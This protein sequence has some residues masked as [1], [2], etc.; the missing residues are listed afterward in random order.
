MHRRFYKFTA[1]LVVC[2]MAFQLGLPSRA[3]LQAKE[4]ETVTQEARALE[5]L[6]RG[7]VA[8]KTEEGVFLSWRLMG[9]EVTGANESNSGL[10]GTNFNLYRD[11]KLIETCIADSTNYI[12]KEGTEDSTYYVC[13]LASD[14]TTEID[15]SENVTVWN[16]NYIEI[17]LNK[18]ENRGTQVDKNSGVGTYAANDMSVADLDGDGEYELLVKWYPSNAKD[19]SQGGYTSPTMIDAYKMDGTFLWRVDLGYNFRSGAHYTQFLVYD[20]D[21]DGKAEMCCKTADGTID[22]VGNVIGDP[23]ATIALE[24]GGHTV[25]GNEYLTVFDGV[26]GAAIDTVPYEPARGLI[27]EWGDKNRGERYLAGMAYLG[28]TSTYANEENNPSLIMCR[29]Y[30]GRSGIAAYDFIDDELV[31][32]WKFDTNEENVS[33]DFSGQGA[34]SLSI[35]D[36]D[37]DGYDEI[38]YGS[39]TIDNDGT[40]LY[41]TKQGHGDALY[42]SDLNINHPGLEVFMVHEKYPKENGIAMHDAATGEFLWGYP[43]VNFD[44]GRGSCGDIDPNYSGNEAWCTSEAEDVWRNG[45]TGYVFASDGT[46]LYGTDYNNHVVAKNTPAFNSMI[47]WDGDLGRELLDHGDWNDATS[48]GVGAIYKWDWEAQEQKLILKADGTYTN[49]GTKNNSCL[50]ADILGDWREEVI[51]RTEDSTAIR[52]YTTTNLTNHKL[53]TL[54]HDS[55]YR[56]AV[57]WQNVGYNQPP[58]LSFYLGFDTNW[59]NIPIPNITVKQYVEEYENRLQT[60][61]FDFGSS[62]SYVEPGYIPVNE[63]SIYSQENGFGIVIGDV[64]GQAIAEKGNALFGDW[65]T[66]DSLTF[67]VDGRKGIHTIKLF[68]ENIDNVTI[69]NEE[70]KF[71]QN[72][73]SYTFSNIQVASEGIL[74]ITITGEKVKLYAMEVIRL[75][76]AAV[77]E[78]LIKEA[79]ELLSRLNQDSYLPETVQAVK[80]TIENVKRA[81]NTNLTEKQVGILTKELKDAMDG[82]KEKPDAPT[83]NEYYFDFGTVSSGVED[84]Y[85]GFANNKVYDA[86]TYYG[87]EQGVDARD[88]SSG[89]KLYTD[90]LVGNDY[91]IKVDLPVGAYQVWVMAGDKSASNSSNIK[92]Q[93]EDIT[94]LRSDSGYRDEVSFVTEVANTMSGKDGTGYGQLEISVSGS[95]ARINAMTIIPYEKPSE[96]AIKELKAAILKAEEKISQSDSSNYLEETWKMAQDTLDYAKKL[97]ENPHPLVS[98]VEKSI[99][100]LLAIIDMKVKPVAPTAMEYLFDLGNGTKEEGYIQIKTSSHYD[101]YTYYGIIGKVDSRER[102]NA[103]ALYG[104]FILGSDYKFQ[105]DLPVGNYEVWLTTGDAENSNTSYVSFQGGDAAQLNSKSGEY[106]SLTSLVSIAQEYTGSDGVG[107]GSLVIRVTGSSAR[108][109]AVKIKPRETTLEEAIGYV[110]EK[111]TQTQN[112]MAEMIKENYKEDAWNDVLEVI[113]YANLVISEPVTASANEVFELVAKI[114]ECY[115]ALLKAVVD[116]E[117]EIKTEWNIDFGTKDSPV[118]DG[119]MQMTGTVLYSDNINGGGQYYGFDREVESADVSGGNYFRDYVYSKGGKPYTFKV[120]LPNGIYN[121]AVL[122]GDKKAANTTKLSFQDYSEVYEQTSEKGAQFK[123]NGVTPVYEVKVTNGTLEVHLYDDTAKEGEISA[124]LN[125]IEICLQTLE[126]GA[127]RTK[128]NKAIEEAKARNKEDYT[129]E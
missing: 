91:T 76:D 127:D 80:D 32:R 1:C 124:R 12:D 7:L 22:G 122:T 54:M 98:E 41:S 43:I 88:R 48:V 65:L 109:N 49:N 116:P 118:E 17:P 3:A 111:I 9:T 87:L 56:T 126:V 66:T 73:N 105:V 40:G 106:A 46:E 96:E 75:T 108:L 52:I 51:F 14:N 99:Q 93:G 67:Q 86:Y 120:D 60:N 34:H 92:A 77:L 100:D 104:D 25:T 74:T 83:T 36:V 5:Y 119:Y 89:D 95:S 81:L 82:L 55:Q 101:P 33:S 72:G 71:V 113:N 64:K 84:G 61:K 125:G 4:V 2:S 63:T 20:F 53:Y 18:P 115:E 30:Y 103:D 21:G 78:T 94:T 45:H 42:V 68:A 19:N 8:V 35:A 59:D 31:L 44:V 62:V 11:G 129:I 110:K 90:F 27:S 123:V 28:S 107:Y 26:T 79:E 117:E 47:W 128:L 6:N 13:A 114:Q 29:G 39:C 85:I 37:D 69:Q 57:A 112:K 70:Q 15:M 23:E 97:L 58:M 16:Q 38:I 50:S 102:S 121:V 24:G 10:D